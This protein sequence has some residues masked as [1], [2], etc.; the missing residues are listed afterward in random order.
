MSEPASHGGL[1]L[2]ECHSGWQHCQAGPAVLPALGPGSESSH[3]DGGPRRG[4][5]SGVGG[6]ERKGGPGPHWFDLTQM[7]R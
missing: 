2:L 6:G 3:R 4:G 1:G 7:T 5:A